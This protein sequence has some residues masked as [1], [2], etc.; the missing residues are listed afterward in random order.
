MLPL[1]EVVFASAVRLPLGKF[2]GSLRDMRVYQLGAAVIPEA[3]RRAGVRPDQVVEV[4]V[5]HNRQSGNGPNPGRTAAVLGGIPVSVP[6]HT[7]NMACPAGLMATVAAARTIR[8]EEADVALVIGMESMSTIP[9]LLRNARWRTFRRGDIVLEDEFFSMVDPLSQMG[10]VALAERTAAKY[11]ISRQ[12][13]ERYAVESHRRAARAWQAGW[14]A[15]EVVPIEVPPTDEREAFTFTRDEC[16]RPD[17]SL[18]AMARLKPVLEGGTVTAATASG[19]TDGA[20]ALV[21]MSRSKART[22]GIRPL[23]S[24]LAYA[25]V[26][27]E[28]EDMLE[29]PVEAIRRVLHKASMKLEDL[30]LIEVNEAFAGQVLANERSLG[31]DQSRLNIHG[32]AIALGH[33]TGFTGVR[34]LITLLHALRTHSGRYGLAAI[35]GGGGLG[36]AVIV[37]REA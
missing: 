14:F 9:H 30:D 37:E 12:E 11:R 20:G 27:V 15:E 32:G 3:L 5:S 35:C 8:L 18:D 13:Q 25:Q 24:L 28:P 19:V 7:I 16:Y 29:G 21:M 4:F 22:L 10:T 2:G 6:A 33:P 36:V 17:A 26:G 1:D 31:W 23:G 34:L